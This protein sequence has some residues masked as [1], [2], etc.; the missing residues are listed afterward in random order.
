MS[1]D[2]WVANWAEEEQSGEAGLYR[3]VYFALILLLAIML[4]VKSYFYGIAVSTASF[5]MFNELVSN[6]VGRPMRF[7]DTT[8]TGTILN[9]CSND[10]AVMDMQIP[11]FL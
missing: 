11:R 9:R 10:M 6:I 1:I 5:S 8:E 3:L 7:F 4:F 2:Y